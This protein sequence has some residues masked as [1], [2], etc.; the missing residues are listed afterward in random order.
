MQAA[1]GTA[2]SR[3][4]MKSLRAKF[5]LKAETVEWFF[6]FAIPF[7]ILGA[8]ILYFLVSITWFIDRGIGTFFHFSEGG[9]MLYGAMAGTAAAAWLAGRVTHQAGSRILDCAAAPFALITAV[10]RGAEYLVGIGLGEYTEEW[11][12]PD[13]G[14]S[15]IQLEDSSFFQ[16]FPFSV[17]DADG[18]WRFPV[19]LLEMLVALLIFLILL[20][21]R[22]RREGTQAL[23]FLAMYAGL[24]AFLESLRIDL[25]LRWGFVK[26]NQLMALPAMAV[27]FAV[28]VFRTPRNNRTLSLFAKPAGGILLCCGV[29]MAMEFALEQKIGFLTWMRMDL[30]WIIMMAAAVVMAWLA[31]GMIRKS[32][33]SFP[34]PEKTPDGRE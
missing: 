30:C 3:L 17:Q 23:L 26:I 10:A 33:L 29:I 12:D 7:S 15:F 11:F 1:A 28:C 27:I 14:R 24:Q 22:T 21:V 34:E 4:V 8:R 31:C 6:L 18:Y 19:F 25:E 20:R 32:D 5:H 13:L 2:L 9:Y 16:R